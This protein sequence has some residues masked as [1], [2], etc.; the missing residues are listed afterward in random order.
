[1]EIL[2]G[3]LL[4][5]ASSHSIHSVVW[6]LTQH[7]ISEDP[8][9]AIAGLLR[10]AAQALTLDTRWFVSMYLIFHGVVKLFLVVSLL[11]ELKWAFS[12]ALWFL[13]I[14]TGYQLYRFAHT[15][16]IALL[17]FSALDIFVMWTVW[18]EYASQ[19]DTKGI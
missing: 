11:R 3:T 9:D 1:M 18:R 7:E 6:L 2:G 17:A 12:L 19:Y 8:A 13:G 15:H 16:S 14:F 5:L 4:L 10:H